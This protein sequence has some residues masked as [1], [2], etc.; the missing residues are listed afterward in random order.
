MLR[1]TKG[2]PT[3]HWLSNDTPRRTHT[4]SSSAV[5]D[6]RRCVD[7]GPVLAWAS[8]SE[9]RSHD[10]SKSCRGTLKRIAPE[11]TSVSHH[12]VCGEANAN[13]K[14]YVFVL[15]LHTQ[16]SGT[17]VSG[18]APHVD[19]RQCMISWKFVIVLGKDL[20]IPDSIKFLKDASHVP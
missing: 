8:K 16:C 19:P 13:K 3:V 2:W 10:R 20:F 14:K 18:G 12:Y 1:V 11:Y 9:W 17:L 5:H 15:A 7:L 4:H 6:Q